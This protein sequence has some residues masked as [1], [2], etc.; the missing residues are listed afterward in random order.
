MSSRLPSLTTLRAFEA[1]SR[2]LSFSKAAEQLGL[3][4]SAV[5]HQI[6]SL[7]AQLSVVL[8]D[9]HTRNVQLTAAGKSF[10]AC[11]HA[12]FDLL[13]AGVD[14]VLAESSETTLRVSTFMS[15]SAKWLIPR[16]N[17]FRT[18]H[19]KIHVR[20][21][22][23][24][25][26]A[27]F[28]NDRIDIAVRTGSGNYPGLVSELICNNEIFP[29]CSPSLLESTPISTFSDLELTTLIHDE[30][31]ANGPSWHDWL[32]YFTK[33]RIK[34]TAHLHFTH[35]NLALEA[36]ISGQ[37]VAL[38]RTPLVADDLAQGRLVRLFDVSLQSDLAYWLIYPRSNARR[39]A[40]RA[41]RDWI[42]GEL[43]SA[44]VEDTLVMAARPNAADA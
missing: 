36:A 35:S 37:G 3:T 28:G 34:P 19:P 13:A 25:E 33:A 44:P 32:R 24:D 16:L 10:A 29:V 18:R 1:T 31:W 20:V 21:D 41:F 4:Q 12:A 27:N 2:L 26:L 43:G 15:F 17:G 5:S 9:R 6:K 39:P 30:G 38:G 22:V 23:R 14:Q 11:V 7:E 8:F 40:V 42:L